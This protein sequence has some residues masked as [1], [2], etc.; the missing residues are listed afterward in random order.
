MTI[1]QI[2]FLTI[3]KTLAA[4]L[5]GPIINY[6]KQGHACVRYNY[7]TKKTR[8]HNVKNEHG[9]PLRFNENVNARYKYV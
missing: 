1:K 4:I 2:L 5:G 7:S 8:T 6:F 3:L 9:I